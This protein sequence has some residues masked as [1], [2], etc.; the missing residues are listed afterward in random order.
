MHDA[1]DEATRAGHDVGVRQVHRRD[2]E[3]AAR[4]EGHE[5]RDD[6][7]QGARLDAVLDERERERR[8]HER[9]CRRQQRL[10][11][12][13]IAREDLERADDE[14][15]RRGGTDDRE[16]GFEAQRD[17]DRHQHVAGDAGGRSVARRLGEDRLQPRESLFRRHG[18]RLGLA[19]EREHAVDL[20]E[21]RR[22]ALLGREV[23]ARLNAIVELHEQHGRQRDDVE[24]GHAVRARDAA[25]QVLA[26]GDRFAARD[27]RMAE[28]REKARQHVGAVGPAAACGSADAVTT[29]RHRREAATHQRGADAS[30]GACWC[31]NAGSVKSDV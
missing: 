4:Q 1:G 17:A 10:Q 25:Q 26:D 27:Q 30:A 5:R 22:D 11:H 24:A 19:R 20:V 21:G 18:E 31:S 15:E 2:R 6:Q 29:V 14:T 28:L 8:D 3:D 13:A 7:A 9:G 12:A 23:E 16:R